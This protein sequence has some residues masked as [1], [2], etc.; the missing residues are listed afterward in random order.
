MRVLVGGEG[1]D[2][3]EGN[4]R[5]GI[6][7]RARYQLRDKGVRRRLWREGGRLHTMARMQ[8]V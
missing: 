2:G 8:G 6:W 4:Q 5:K 3:R 1:V 7:H